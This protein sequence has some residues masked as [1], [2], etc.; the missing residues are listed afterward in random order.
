LVKATAA[1]KCDLE[2]DQRSADQ[3][4]YFRDQPI[5]GAAAPDGSSN[6]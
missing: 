3:W 6:G 2:I 5:Q 4:P 1:E